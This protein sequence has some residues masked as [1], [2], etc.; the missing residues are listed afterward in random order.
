MV[1]KKVSM[2]EKVKIKIPED[3]ERR[4]IFSM[5]VSV[6]LISTGILFVVTG[7]VLFGLYKKQPKIDRAIDVPIVS[8]LPI[9]TNSKDI[10][11]KGTVKDAKSVMIWVNDKLIE[12][13]LSVQ[14]S[15]FR[16]VYRIEK[17]G[18]YKVEVASVKGFPVRLRSQKS[19]PQTITADWSVP[20]KVAKLEYEK[21]VDVKTFTLNGIIDPDTTIVIEGNGKKY[22][23]TS[24]SEGSFKIENIDV[25]LGTNSFSIQ[26]R[27]QAG[28]VTSL[29]KRV[30]VA[31]TQGSINGDGIQDL[32]ESAGNLSL[33]NEQSLMS[34][35]GV[36]I[37]SVL[38]FSSTLVLVRVKRESLQS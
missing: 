31:M 33:Y 14:D 1:K 12:E 26:L 18:A 38:L 23:S 16:C 7:V 19:V 28:N 15:N 11:V 32:P 21:E 9:N 3:N 20:S 34:T 35:F 27:D 22:V 29:D 37:L 17:E 25:T 30:V 10:V 2:Q 4:N 6:L 13:S 5:F 36:V 24:D 8:S